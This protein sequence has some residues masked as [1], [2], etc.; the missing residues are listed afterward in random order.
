MEYIERYECA[1][2]CAKEYLKIRPNKDSD[3][4]PNKDS[5]EK[6]LWRS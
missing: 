1:C 3:E 2:I 5:D 4:E 6:T